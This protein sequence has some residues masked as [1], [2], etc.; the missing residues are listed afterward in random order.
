MGLFY[1]TKRLSVF[2]IRKREREVRT[3]RDVTCRYSQIKTWRILGKRK[4]NKRYHNRKDGKGL[5]DNTEYM[6]VCI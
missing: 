6:E 4:E 3:K 1:F 2:I 5:L